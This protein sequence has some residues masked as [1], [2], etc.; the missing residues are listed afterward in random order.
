MNLQD[1]KEKIE[2]HGRWL[3]GEDGGERA[4]LNEANLTEADLTG[5]N[6]YGANLTGANLTE[7]TLT[8]AKIKNMALIGSCPVFSC[9]PI[10]SRA[11]YLLAYNTEKGI[12]IE[13]GCF[14]GSVEEFESAVKR[15]HSGKRHERDYLSAIVMIKAIFGKEEK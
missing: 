2:K 5:A 7:A 9:G 1:L 15:V 3:H 8:G 10:G 4:N 11:A 13:A 6:L 12:F 14:F